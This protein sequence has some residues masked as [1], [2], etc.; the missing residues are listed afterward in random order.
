M[1]ILGDV[2][3]VVAGGYDMFNSSDKRKYAEKQRQVE[4]N[5]QK[6]FAQNSIAW[7]VEDAKRSG[8]HP[9]YALSGQGAS[10]T[11]S[12]VMVDGGTP[13]LEQMSQGM[14]NLGNRL[15]TQGERA[16][17][18]AQLES[19]KAS[20]A[21]DRAIGAYYDNESGRN[22]NANQVSSPSQGVWVREDDQ[23][24]RITNEPSPSMDKFADFTK[25]VPSVV[26]SPSSADLGVASGS[27]TLW[28]RYT[29]KKGM[30][31]ILPWSNEGPSETL[32]EM[33][34]MTAWVTWKKN[35]D[36]FGNEHAKRVMNEVLGVP[37]WILNAFENDPNRLKNALRRWG[38][39]P[40]TK[41][42]EMR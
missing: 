17:A 37:Y 16:I 28:K 13:G 10:Y 5:R 22:R 19:I 31:V 24:N 20:A 27:D 33:G 15:Q 12:S 35:Q 40:P 34:P 3:D 7:R 42:Q 2:W 9:L 32:S 25:V 6:E 18:A 30:E 39:L 41:R 1:G 11:P 29:H 14:R 36:A 21:K 38:G 23:G 26:Q 8:L 4:F